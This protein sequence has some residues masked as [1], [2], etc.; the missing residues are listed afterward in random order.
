MKLN[1]KERQK[2]RRIE[3]RKRREDAQRTERR[4]IIKILNPEQMKALRVFNGSKHS[5]Q[6]KSKEDMIECLKMLM[7]IVTTSNY[8]D[9]IVKTSRRGISKTWFDRDIDKDFIS[10]ILKRELSSLE[11]TSVESIAL[12]LSFWANRLAHHIEDEVIGKRGKGNMNHLYS[13]YFLNPKYKYDLTTSKDRLYD[14]TDCKARQTLEEILRREPKKLEG[15]DAPEQLNELFIGLNFRNELW[16]LKHQMI[17]TI[18][19]NTAR[20]ESSPI[21]VTAIDE[22]KQFIENSPTLRLIIREINGIAPVIM[23][24]RKEHIEDFVRR[25]GLNPIP[26]ET[27]EKLINFSKKSKIGIHFV[28]SEEDAEILEY[29]ATERSSAKRL[30]NVFYKGEQDDE[31]R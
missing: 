16:T 1:N 9:E 31:E 22:D 3:E 7:T 20:N 26:E 14:G 10:E 8:F 29:E 6:E 21:K 17:K 15:I 11:D 25:N 13:K 2:Q 19:L 12:K 27:S 24:C 4:K 28:M 23:H 30:H 18:L 5:N